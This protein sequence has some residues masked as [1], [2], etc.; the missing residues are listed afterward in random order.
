MTLEG[1]DI[2]VFSKFHAPL[3]FIFWNDTGSLVRV[4]NIS[5]YSIK[6]KY[7]SQFP[8]MDA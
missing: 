4:S 6:Y 3:F 7:L 1:N 2:I 5:P 8:L